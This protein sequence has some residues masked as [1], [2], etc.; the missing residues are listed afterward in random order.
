MSL[1]RKKN[2][3]SGL[4]IF[5]KYEIMEHDFVDFYDAFGAGSALSPGLLNSDA[6]L[7]DKG[8]LYAKI[9]KD[10]RFIHFFNSHTISDFSSNQHDNRVLQYGLIDDFIKSKSIPEDE[11]VII[12]GDLNEDKNCSETSYMEP[13][14]QDQEYYNTMLDILSAVDPPLVGDLQFTYTPDNDFIKN[15]S[16]SALYDYLLYRDGHLIPEPSTSCKIIS[17]LGQDGEHLSD[18]L[19]LTCDY[20]LLIE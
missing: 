12:G 2:G 10:D 17:A 9:I 7:F 8:V 1:E 15:D 19:P 5:S 3:G 14:C 13:V 4:A 20:Q 18:H 11:L 16:G 6:Y